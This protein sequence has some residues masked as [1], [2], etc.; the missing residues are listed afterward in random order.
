M[1]RLTLKQLRIVSEIARNGKIVSAAKELGV[2]PP[3]V[4]L[5]LQLLE[6]AAGLPLFERTKGGMRPTDAGQVLVYAARR[7]EKVLQEGSEAV[8]TLKGIGGCRVKVGFVSTAKYFA[9][10]ALAAFAIQHPAIEMQ[11][12]IGNRERTLA[13]L[14]D[15]DLDL[16]ITGYP[17]EDMAFEK[18]VIGD[19]PHVIIAAPDH[20]L[21]DRGRIKLDKLANEIFLV[22]EPG[23]GTRRLME[24]LFAGAGV[25]P[26]VGMEIES[27]E[28]IKQF[29]MAGL[30]LAVIS[31][32]TV[33]AEV[34][35]GRLVMLDVR[36]L[37]VMR[38]WYVLRHAEKR[39]LP[40]ASAMWDFLVSD[41]RRFLPPVLE[42]S[43]GK[44]RARPSRARTPS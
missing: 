3:A 26:R 31:A 20:H 42:P 17:P 23:S 21:A 32:H 43:L 24:R 29:V 40:A 2:T 41:G 7:V 35:S 16:A 37:P 5:Q 22:R 4:T 11:L 30:G 15:L 44:A 6:A 36:G 38:K 12:L 9:A 14:A 13:A 18:R 27:N 33:A 39:L 10:R 8:K 28:T 19:H 25:T 34:E 1:L